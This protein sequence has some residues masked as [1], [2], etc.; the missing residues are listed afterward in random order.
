MLACTKL[1]LSNGALEGMNNKI[2]LVSHRA[3]GCRTVEHYVAAIYHLLCQAAAARGKLITLLGEEPVFLRCKTLLSLF[4]D[5]GCMTQSSP[6][7]LRQLDSGD[8]ERAF[9]TA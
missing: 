1:R 8:L 7:S 2:K 9:F 5:G 4:S 6:Q 3:F